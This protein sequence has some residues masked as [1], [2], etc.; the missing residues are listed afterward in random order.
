MTRENGE[1]IRFAKRVGIVCGAAVMAGAV[2]QAVGGFMWR[3]AMRPTNEQL[4]ALQLGQ[5][6]ER[7]SRQHNDSLLVEQIA[8]VADA[9]R[10]PQGSHA[11]E[12]AAKEAAQ[13]PVVL[14][15]ELAQKRTRP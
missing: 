2:L 1:F 7:T 15:R 6:E 11:S 4:Q 9:V 10:F 8:M 12:S 13:V 5:T 14:K 3:T